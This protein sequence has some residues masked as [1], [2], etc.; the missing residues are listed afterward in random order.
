MKTIIVTNSEYYH[1]VERPKLKFVRTLLLAILD[2]CPAIKVDPVLLKV[3]NLSESDV[4]G[5]AAVIDDHLISIGQ[6][7]I[8]EQDA[9][10][11]TELHIPVELL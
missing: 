3:R 10:G 4:L 6:P 5:L 2:N 11:I 1:E 8:I 7:G 9:D